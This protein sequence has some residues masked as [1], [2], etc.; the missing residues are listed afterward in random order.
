[1]QI[2]AKNVFIFPNNS[3]ICLVAEQ[4]RRFVE[5]RNVFVI[6]TK[7]VPQGISALMQF[8]PD[9]SAEDNRQTMLEAMKAVKTLD[10]TYAAHDSTVDGE[11]VTCGQILGLVEHKVRYVA[12]SQAECMEKMLPELEGAS[13]ITVF[14]GSDVS[15]EEANETLAF[16]Q[17]KAPDTEIALLSGGQPLY[18]YVISVE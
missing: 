11:S 15:E 2:P 8:D 9:A 7:S 13:Y 18:Y 5:D 17:S 4:V 14:Y 6:P 12:D 1:L 16:L 10:M 3:N